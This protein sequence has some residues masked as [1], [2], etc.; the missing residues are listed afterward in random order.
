MDEQKQNKRLA[1]QAKLG[2]HYRVIYAMLVAFGVFGIVFNGCRGVV[3][4]RPL[5]I[6][7]ITVLGWASLRILMEGTEAAMVLMAIA[8]HEDSQKKAPGKKDDAGGPPPPV[9]PA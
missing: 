9:S 3:D 6:L 5:V 2:L 1:F 7:I 8:K 4:V